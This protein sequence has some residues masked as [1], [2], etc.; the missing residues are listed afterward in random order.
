[1]FTRRFFIPVLISA[2]I[3]SFVFQVQ[4]VPVGS[5][6]ASIASDTERFIGTYRREFIGASGRVVELLDLRA[7]LTAT[8]TGDYENRGDILNT[9]N[10]TYARSRLIVT[11]API[12]VGGTSWVIEFRRTGG[13]WFRKGNDLRVTSSTPSGIVP[14]GA[15]YKRIRR[16]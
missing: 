10:W 1:M 14:N 15:V 2:F 5:A 7:D 9:G 4:G 8:M 11:F 13:R 3:V 6:N 12:E 16:G